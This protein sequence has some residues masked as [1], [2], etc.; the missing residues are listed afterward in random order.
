MTLNDLR[1]LVAVAQTGHFG[2]AAE[3]CFVA[4]P[5][6]SVAIKKLEEELGVQLLVRGAQV[7]LTAVGEHIVE[8]AQRVL[9]EA[10]RIQALADAGRDPLRGPLKLGVIYTIAPFLLPQLYASLHQQAP[11]MPLLLQENYTVPL[12]EAL[13]RGDLDAVILALPFDTQGLAITPLYDEPFYVALPPGHRWSAQAQVPVQQ[14]AEETVLL[15]SRGNC[16]RDQVLAA[17]PALNL[18]QREHPWQQTLEGS[19]LNT[20][21]LM[22]AHGVGVTVLP[23]AAAVSDT[24]LTCRPLVEPEPFRRVVLVRRRSFAREPALAVLTQILATQALPGTRSLL[25]APAG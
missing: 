16:F 6:L 20:I 11:D 2:R 22:V 17:C 24:L 14:L 19:S 4:Q 7:Q 13:R 15:L 12:L 1:Y 10:R 8:Q 25:P 3:R 18:P 5:T 9:E 23:A 21:R